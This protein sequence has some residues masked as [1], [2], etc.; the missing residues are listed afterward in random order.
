MADAPPRPVRPDGGVALAADVAGEHPPPPPPRSA[1]C[2]SACHQR[3]R[4][5]AAG[6]RRRRWLQAQHLRPHD[7]RV[8]ILSGSDVIHSKP[9]PDIYLLA[10]EQLEVDPKECVVF[11]D[12]QAGVIAA[13]SA[14]MTV[15][16]VPNFFTSH[17]DHS[18]ADRILDNLREAIAL[19]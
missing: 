13:N 6:G 12:S 14:G 3:A 4:H 19:L 17:Q 1:G 9:A 11:E 15:F 10:A 5:S 18:Q 8:A 2:R 7:K 16:A